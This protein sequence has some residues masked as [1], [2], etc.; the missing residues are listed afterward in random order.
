MT[1]KT[2][3]VDAALAYLRE[4]AEEH[5]AGLDEFLRIESVS[6]DRSA[7]TRCAAPRSGWPT[8]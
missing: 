4:H 3:G 7:R 6:A 5:R 8:S 1:V 2:R